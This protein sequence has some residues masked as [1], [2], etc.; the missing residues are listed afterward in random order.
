MKEG[1]KMHLGKLIDEKR[2]EKG[3]TKIWLAEKI[4][5]NYKTFVRRIK[6][7][8]FKAEELLRISV[9]LGIDLEELKNQNN[10]KD[11]L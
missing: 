5:V 7:G 11:G 1:E 10:R 9:V 8:T 4:K 6:T 2:K 3:H